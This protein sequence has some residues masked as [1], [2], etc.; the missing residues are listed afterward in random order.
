MR[1][2]IAR[3]RT[4]AKSWRKCRP[5]AYAPVSTYAPVSAAP[6]LRAATASTPSFRSSE[7]L[8]FRLAGCRPG[9]LAETVMEAGGG[10]APS[11][12]RADVGEPPASGL[13]A[14]RVAR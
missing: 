9:A 4:R 12:T 6:T 10:P 2:P 3:R 11:H 14:A 7:R 8:T 13:S 5:A 1:G